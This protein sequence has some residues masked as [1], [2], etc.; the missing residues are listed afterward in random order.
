MATKKKDTLRASTSRG[1]GGCFIAYLTLDWDRGD[2]LSGYGNTRRSA[3]RDVRAQH[4]IRMKKE[5]GV[6]DS[7]RSS[8]H[9]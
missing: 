8:C 4:K 5:K 3:I 9:D 1:L 2:I 6:T 7:N